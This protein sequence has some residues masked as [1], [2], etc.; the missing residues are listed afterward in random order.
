MRRHALL[1]PMSP[2]RVLLAASGAWHLRNT[3]KAFQERDALA[4]LW[5]SDRNRTGIA[6]ERY[7]RC[8]PFHLAMMPF[9]L[10]RNDHWIERVFYASLPLWKLWV[11]RQAL[12][13]CQVVQAIMGYATE[14]F[15]R[16]NG[17]RILKVVDCQNSHPT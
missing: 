8:W 1:K 3:A 14:L 9:Y 5:C 4:A 13:D 16:M 10:S 15:E 17:R 12:P 6:V 11:K 2:M 7:R